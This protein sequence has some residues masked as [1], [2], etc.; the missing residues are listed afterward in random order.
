MYVWTDLEHIEHPTIE[1]KIASLKGSNPYG[2]CAWKCDNDVVDHQSVV[3]EFAD[4]CT[5]TLNMIGGSARLMRS[6]HLVGTKGEI[7]GRFE[8]S[9]FIIRHMDLR[10]GHE[11]TEETVKLNVNEDTSGASGGH[12]GG[13]VRMVADFVSLLRGETPSIS[14]TSIED[15]VAGHLLGFGADCS[16]EEN[17]V[18][19]IDVSAI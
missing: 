17:R 12:G 9:E 7:Q 13:D 16:R 15:S 1:D 18:V 6:I 10:P 8:D 2:R 19:P 11:Y 14:S 3:I 4:G 5:A